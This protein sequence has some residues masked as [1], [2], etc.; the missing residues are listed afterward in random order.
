MECS[1]KNLHLYVTNLYNYQINVIHDIF[2]RIFNRVC[3]ISFQLLQTNNCNMIAIII[4][5][6]RHSKNDT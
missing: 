5:Y 2:S 1:N 6:T 4:S 3:I